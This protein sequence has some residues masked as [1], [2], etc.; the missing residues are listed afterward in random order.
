M[1]PLFAVWLIAFFS[2]SNLSAASQP[3][4]VCCERAGTSITFDAYWEL[5]SDT[6]Q[7]IVGL[8]GKPEGTVTRELNLLASQW[9]QITAVENPD[10]S[11]IAIDPAYLAA[12]LRRTP[13]DLKRLEN[14]FDALLQAHEKYPRQVFTLEDVLPLKEIL[15]RPEFQWQESRTLRTPNLLDK[16]LDWIENLRD[17]A[18]NATFRFGRVPLIIAAVLLFLL[19]LFFISRGLSRNL[20]REAELE[21]EGEEDEALLS[22]KGALKRAETLSTQGDYRNAIRYLYLSSLLVLDEQGLMRYDRSRTNRE[23]LRSVSSKPELAKPLQ[24][25][26]DVFDRVW[27]GFEGVDEKTYRSYVERVD[28]LREKKE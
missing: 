8:K 27:Y 20:V 7:T 14:E 18:M 16:F 15:K 17:R 3:A 1:R 2:L 6:R 4:E 25:V 12:E 13:A 23:Y 21:N 22:S 26:I 10:R 24:D 19:S 28:E 11:V 5:V 9:E